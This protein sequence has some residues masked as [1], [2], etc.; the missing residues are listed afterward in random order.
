[1][2]CCGTVRSPMVTVTSIPRPNTETVTATSLNLSAAGPCAQATQAQAHRGLGRA[3]CRGAVGRGSG[4]PCGQRAARESTG[5]GRERGRRP[6]LRASASQPRFAGLFVGRRS[7][8]AA[9]H[10]PGL[11]WHAGAC[12]VIGP[13]AARMA[14]PPSR[15]PRH[16]CP[17]RY[18]F[19][20]VRLR[21]MC[22][23]SAAETA[24]VAVTASEPAVTDPAPDSRRRPAGRP[25]R[26]RMRLCV[27][28]WL[29][30]QLEAH[31]AVRIGHV[32]PRG[33][34]LYSSMAKP[35]FRYAGFR[36]FAGVC[37][38]LLLTL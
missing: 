29:L 1:M 3:M 16:P 5:D 25:R 9:V 30:D 24:A 19:G 23:P 14:V 13:P 11:R 33:H 2:P 4:L 31:G 17:W 35:T 20:V 15:A 37:R 22:A 38:P 26:A 36:H 10:A 34:G 21:V 12:K 32:H 6:C 28:L 8:T 18:R 7:A 27:R